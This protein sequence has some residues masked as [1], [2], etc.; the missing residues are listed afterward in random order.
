VPTSTKHPTESELARAAADLDHTRDQFVISMGELEREIARDLDWR[1][2]VRRKPGM[3]LAL[4][5]GLGF[6]L[7]RRHRRFST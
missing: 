1:E 6:F 7:V 2:W 3:A 4:A 5:F